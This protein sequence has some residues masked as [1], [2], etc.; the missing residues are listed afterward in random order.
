M[1]TVL[2]K[3]L[4]QLFVLPFS[5]RVIL[6]KFAPFRAG[7]RTLEYG[8]ASGPDPNTRIRGHDVSGVSGEGGKYE[9]GSPPLI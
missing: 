3:Q 9:R 7:P 2:G 4:C 8:K 1:G 5:S 6:K